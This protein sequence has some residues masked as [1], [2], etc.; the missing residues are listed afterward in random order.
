MV[1]KQVQNGAVS[2]TCAGG[3]KH[4]EVEKNFISVG[5]NS[6]T[7]VILVYAFLVYDTEKKVTQSYE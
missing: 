2:S 1:V 5:I 3:M 4:Q 7:P 6:E